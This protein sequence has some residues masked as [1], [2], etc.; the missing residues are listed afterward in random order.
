MLYGILKIIAILYFKIFYNFKVFGKEN[1]PTSGGYIVSPNHTHWLDIPLVGVALPKRM[2]SFAKKELFERRIFAL[3][4]KSLGGIPVNREKPEITSIRLSREILQKGYPLL[5]FPEGTRSRTG[6]L[7]KGKR[8]AIYFSTIAKVPIVPVG[9]V[10][11]GRR[12]IHVKRTR[13]AVY[14]GKHFYPY[15]IFDPND[16]DYYEKAT[17]YLMEKVREC[18]EK[19]EELS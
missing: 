13:L 10:G 18:I 5:L 11:L 17:N 15:E 8:G 19:A 9:I 6:E 7:L 16:K 1:L 12:F 4:L 2:Y 14:F 3:I